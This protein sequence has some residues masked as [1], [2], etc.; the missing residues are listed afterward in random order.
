VSPPH[1]NPIRSMVFNFFIRLLRKNLGYRT[2]SP[3][4]I[5]QDRCQCR[6][7]RRRKDKYRRRCILLFAG[8]CRWTIQ[9]RH[10]QARQQVQQRI[11]VSQ[12]ERPVV[13]SRPCRLRLRGGLGGAHAK[14]AIPETEDERSLLRLGGDLGRAHL[15]RV[16]R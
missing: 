4:K 6:L 1:L 7:C 3:G 11:S 5:P 9:A 15:L 12:S 10:P 14:P 2:T 16:C 13:L 8:A